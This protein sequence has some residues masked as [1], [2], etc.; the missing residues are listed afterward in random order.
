KALEYVTANKAR[1]GVQIVNL[2]LG[3]PI[4][5]PASDD[6]LVAAVERATDAGLIVVASAGNFGINQ[7]TGQPG[8]TGITS[9]GNAPSALTVGATDT[10]NTTTRADDAVAPYSSRGPSWF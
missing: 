7:K 9:P 1:L 3:H 6:P 5:A 4:F 10:K 2:S 8:Y